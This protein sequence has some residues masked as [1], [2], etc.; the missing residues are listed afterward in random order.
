[1]VSLSKKEPQSGGAQEISR[2]GIT[3]KIAAV[4]ILVLILVSVLVGLVLVVL[5][6]AERTAG[7][8]SS[9]SAPT[10]PG[11]EDV[12][13]AAKRTCVKKPHAHKAWGF[14]IWS[15]RVLAD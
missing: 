8:S 5:I 1:V 10:S 14:S 9:S 11:R 13:A 3:A 2:I 6:L 4:I 15:G 12:R 7:Q